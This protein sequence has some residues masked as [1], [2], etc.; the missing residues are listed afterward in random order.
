MIQLVSQLCQMIIDP[1]LCG[2]HCRVICGKAVVVLPRR[3]KIWISADEQACGH[4]NLRSVNQSRHVHPLTAYEIMITISMIRRQLSHR[5]QR[6]GGRD[7]NAP[8]QCCVGDESGYRLLI[9]RFTRMMH[10]PAARVSHCAMGGGAGGG[11]ADGLGFGDG[12]VRAVAKPAAGAWA[13]RCKWCSGERWR[14]SYRRPARSGRL[15]V[16]LP[17]ASGAGSSMLNSPSADVL[18][19]LVSAAPLLAVLTQVTTVPG[20]EWGCAP[21]V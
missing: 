6:Q 13:A 2:A 19:L 12:W 7:A 11:E 3:F 16:T 21:G 1:C 9:D 20:S 18:V 5:R 4:S 15:M 17:G 10:L 8:R 14:C